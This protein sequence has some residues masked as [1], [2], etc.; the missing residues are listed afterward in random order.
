[1]GCMLSDKDEKFVENFIRQLINVKL[2][3][4]VLHTL[5]L[6]QISV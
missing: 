6:I 1:M 4:I 3:L 2:K 5:L